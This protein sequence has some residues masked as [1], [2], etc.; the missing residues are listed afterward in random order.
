M[1]NTIIDINY[2]N[3]LIE[4]I[5]I[6]SNNE[7]FNMIIEYCNMMKT[8]KNISNKT[9]EINNFI[10]I[11]N[12]YLNEIRQNI[13]KNNNIVNK[14]NNKSYILNNGKNE[15][16]KKHKLTVEAI[17]ESMIHTIIFY[18]DNELTV[19]ISANV[20]SNNG[21]LNQKM[22]RAE[23]ISL[24]Y[25][26][27]N[28]YNSDM[29]NEDKNTSLLILLKNIANK[30]EI[31]QNKCGFIHGDFHSGNIFVSNEDITF[32]DFGYSTIRIPL[33]NNNN[34]N[35]LI[36]TTPEESNINRKYSL[37]I[38]TDPILKAIDMFYLLEDF[39]TFD[40]TKFNTQ[41]DFDLFM[42]FI[43]DIR[44]LY[45][46][47]YNKK[48]YLKYGNKHFFTSSSNF[49]NNDFEILYPENF[50]NLT[51]EKIYNNNHSIGKRSSNN[52][53]SNTNSN[54]YNFNKTVKKPK[55]LFPFST[56]KKDNNDQHNLS[57]DL[58]RGSLFDN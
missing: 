28:I 47:N 52:S 23:G 24:G 25:F 34:N 13:I 3:I 57:K 14:K 29:L 42:S 11:I 26:I 48:T 2:Y 51:I 4:K 17:I 39:L 12:N 54:N 56:I 30:L 44:N 5:P 22:H 7:L 41:N 49:G 18:L 55:P 20:S 53:N 19:N 37:D 43:K 32:I 1:N 15:I 40:R 38:L 58:F 16:V 31:L 8:S 21:R 35:Y 46:K 45:M 10:K 9:Y 6:L 27:L 36:L 33:K 50:K